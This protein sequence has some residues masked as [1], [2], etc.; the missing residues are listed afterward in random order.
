MRRKANQVGWTKRHLCHRNVQPV[1]PAIGGL[2]GFLGIAG[3]CLTEYEN[4]HRPMHGHHKQKSIFV[5]LRVWR[6]CNQL[7]MRMP[8]KQAVWKARFPA[9]GR[10]R[11][12]S[13][14][15]GGGACGEPRS[16]R[17]STGGPPLS[18]GNPRPSTACEGDDGCQF[19]GLEGHASLDSTISFKRFGAT[20]ALPARSL[21]GPG[22][23]PTAASL[24]GA[25]AGGPC[26]CRRV[27]S[28]RVR[29][30]PTGVR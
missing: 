14:G 17:F 10:G 6:P 9:A 28:G 22:N 8:S 3:F 15:K 26:G 27:R 4:C 11:R 2:I 30:G 20:E 21:A 1:G 12:V 13:C 23:P 7:M 19:G 18:T 24:P 16:L 5:C 25:Q 29:H